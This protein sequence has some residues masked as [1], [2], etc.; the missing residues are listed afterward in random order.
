[1]W[2]IYIA[3]VVSIDSCLRL[4]PTIAECLLFVFY[5]KWCA[6]VRVCLRVTRGEQGSVYDG[7]MAWVVEFR[8]NIPSPVERLVQ[9]MRRW[10]VFFWFEDGFTSDCMSHYVLSSLMDSG[11]TFLI[12]WVTIPAAVSMD[13]SDNPFRKNLSLDAH[14]R[15]CN[16]LP[17]NNWMC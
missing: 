13:L 8:Q 17:F 15:M 3:W 12:F 9:Q 7:V 1:M 4:L 2:L 6:C 11:V 16:P 14:W 5:W 10:F